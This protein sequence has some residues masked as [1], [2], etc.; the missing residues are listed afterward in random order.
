[1]PVTSFRV[2]G[3][4]RGSDA[5]ADRN[6][7]PANSAD[8]EVVLA[9]RRGEPSAELDAWNRFSPGIDAALRRMLGPAGGEGAEREDLL[10]EVFLRF[11]RRVGTLREPAAVRG[12]LTSICLRVVQTEIA[13]RRRRRWLRLTDTGEPPEAAAPRH[14][15]DAREAVARYYRLLD[16][17]SGRERSLL[18]ARTIEG[19]TLEEV[20]AAH[21]ISISTAQRHLVRATKRIATLVRRDPVLVALAEATEAETP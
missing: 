6:E 3:P 16:T 18:V 11:F 15:E 21:G 20:A 13:S 12:F 7:R 5:G 19:L 10:Q 17:L 9:L 1:M 8:V 2:L 4:P 14:D